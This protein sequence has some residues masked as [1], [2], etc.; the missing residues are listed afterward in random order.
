[1]LY[2]HRIPLEWA[3]ICSL[4]PLATLHLSKSQVLSGI[5]IISQGR[6]NTRSE[7]DH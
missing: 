6:K 1:M 2:E 4:A 5:D 7:L 3:E